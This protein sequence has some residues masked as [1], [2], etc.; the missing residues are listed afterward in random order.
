MPRFEGTKR[1]AGLSESCERHDESGASLRQSSKRYIERRRSLIELK[2][3]ERETRAL[4]IERR[5]SLMMS[6]E[7]DNESNVPVIEVGKH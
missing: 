7:R 2:T 6:R 3:R 4:D 5:S 1:D